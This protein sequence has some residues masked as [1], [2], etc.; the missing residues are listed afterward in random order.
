[1]LL[2][3][4][5]YPSSHLLNNPGCLAALD[6]IEATEVNLFVLQFSQNVGAADHDQERK[7]GEE[8][9]VK[10]KDNSTFNF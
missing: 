2:C 8:I 9:M 5:P 7:K 10:G 6:I 4:L 3:K 1:M